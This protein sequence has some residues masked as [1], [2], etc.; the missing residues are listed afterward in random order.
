MLSGEAW[1]LEDRAWLQLGASG[2]NWGTAHWA[3]GAAHD[4]HTHNP[5]AANK[6]RA[7]C[8]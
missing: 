5:G 7:K 1:R 4:K 8:P 2:I 3:S 6:A